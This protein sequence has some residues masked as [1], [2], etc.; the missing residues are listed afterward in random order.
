[1]QH[2]LISTSSTTSLSSGL[3]DFPVHAKNDPAWGKIDRNSATRH[4]LANHSLDVAFVFQQLASMSRFGIPLK[5]GAGLP[6]SEVHHDRLAVLAFLHDIGKIHW[7]FQLRFWQK[8]PQSE[9]VRHCDAALGLIH[10]IDPERS[11]GKLM[12]EFKQWFEGYEDYLIAAF[13]HHGT[14]PEPDH[15]FFNRSEWDNRDYD[16]QRECDRLADIARSAFP[17]A[18]GHAHRLPPNQPFIHHIAGMIALSDM[19][20]SD[21]KIFRFSLETTTDYIELSQRRAAKSVRSMALSVTGDFP[22]EGSSFILNGQAARPLQKAMI[23]L[24]QQSNIEILEAETGAGKTEAALIRFYELCAAGQVDGMFFAL[25]SRSAARQIHKR[26]SDAV[27]RLFGGYGPEVILAIPG[28]RVAGD[29]IARRLPGFETQWSDGHDHIK[30]RWSAEHATRFM[31]SV[32]SVGTIEQALLSAIQIKHAQLRGAALARSLLIIDE[33]HASD[34]IIAKIIKQ[35]IDNHTLLGGRVMM[36]SASLGSEAR[37]RFLEQPYEKLE[38]AARVPYP[39]IWSDR[40]FYELKPSLPSKNLKI[41]L[42]DGKN[43]IPLIRNII[44]MSTNGA[45]ILVIRNTASEAARFHSE[46]I[47]QGGESLLLQVNGKRPIHSSRYCPEDRSL[48]DAALEENF[49]VVNRETPGAGCIVVG[50]QTLEQCIDVDCDLLV[51][52]LCPMDVLLQRIG[53]VHRF[54]GQ[55]KNRPY[56]C[57][58]AKVYVIDLPFDL[59]YLSEPRYHNGMGMARHEGRYRGLYTDLPCLELTRRSINNL[60]EWNLPRDTRWLVE[61]CTH[62]EERARIISEMGWSYYEGVLVS[63]TKRL[64]STED[65]ILDRM[66]RQPDQYHGSEDLILSSISEAGPYLK[67][68]SGYKTPLGADLTSMP[69]PAHWDLQNY[70]GTISDIILD[71]DG[72]NF[73][74]DG[75]KIRY[76]HLGIKLMNREVRHPINEHTSTA[77]ELEYSQDHLTM[78][79]ELGIL[80]DLPKISRRFT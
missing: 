36:M 29:A 49:S 79:P 6:L 78:A 2:T 74:I 61:S 12:H 69:F 60:P 3:S 15:R 1:M 33:V 80:A 19:I 63:R 56:E 24:T 62:S 50:T 39:C 66:V 10:C 65:V 37:R 7:R 73:E 34:Q 67:F 44:Q 72:L 51:T 28:Q 8:I 11:F 13:S 71:D 77:L 40:G 30:S 58:A 16:W 43:F 54:G 68:N 32:I 26:I 17:L 45:K 22:V 27:K 31:A 48:I 46:I 38:E 52:D 42:S 76:D 21:E 35:L 55:I 70:K 57:Q 53:R 23:D 18:F 47:Q 41:N 75:V 25:P 4:A 20:G 64:T 9:N 59:N 14:P 5:K